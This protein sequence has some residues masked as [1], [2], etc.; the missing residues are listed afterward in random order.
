MN[1][2]AASLGLPGQLTSCTRPMKIHCFLGLLARPF[3][4]TLIVF[5]DSDIVLFL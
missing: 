1:V 5:K 2:P 3:R 4:S